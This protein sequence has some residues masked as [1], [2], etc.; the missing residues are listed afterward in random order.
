MTASGTC[1]PGTFLR[2][3]SA[4]FAERSG[5]TPARIKTLPRQTERLDL[6]H[7]AAQQRQVVAV[8]RLDELRARRDLLGQALWPPSRAAGPRDF[9]RRRE[10][11]AAR[12]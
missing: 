3:H 1:M 6:F 11:R 9:Q 4:V 8:L 7:E 2:I 5:P 10:T 12:S